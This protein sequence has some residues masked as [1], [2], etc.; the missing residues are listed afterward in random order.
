MSSI[1][2][3]DVKSISNHILTVLNTNLVQISMM[4][5]QC[6]DGAHVMSGSVSGV[7]DRIKYMNPEAIYTHCFSHRLNLAL[8][9]AMRGAGEFSEILGLLSMLYTF[10]SASIVHIEFER[11]QIQ[12]IEDQI[13]DEL[14]PISLK[15]HPVTR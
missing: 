11:E 9:N 7:Q 10:L 13:I 8:V 1:D 5:F 15:R 3:L 6:Y 14:P 12:L 2:G 4:M